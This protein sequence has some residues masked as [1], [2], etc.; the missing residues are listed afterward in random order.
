MN[1]ASLNWN[2]IGVPIAY[3]TN[4]KYHGKVV[5][6]LNPDSKQ[7]SNKPKGILRNTN[8]PSEDEIKLFKQ[9]LK[10]GIDENGKKLNVKLKNQIQKILDK[11]DEPSAIR[12]LIVSDGMIEVIPESRVDENGKDFPAH[13]MV[14]G[15]TGS[16]KTTWIKKYCS[17]LLNIK[18]HK[19]VCIFSIHKEGED[20][21]LS[22]LNPT[23][24]TCDQK[25]VDS[26]PQ[27]EDF[28]D[29]ICLFDDVD[30]ISD[31]KVN[32]FVA[33]FRDSL[34]QNGRHYNCQVITVSHQI[35]NY[36]RTKA[37]IAEV[38]YF[39]IFPKRGMA[40][41]IRS[42]LKDNLGLK[43]NMVEK[44]MNLDTRAC[45]ISQWFPQ[46]CIA[47]HNVFFTNES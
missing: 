9:I 18:S 28:K 8:R 12:E 43:K 14:T 35:K 15:T 10:K 38:P 33:D 36:T 2:R 26:N 21:S 42:F 19:I 30:L 20:G 7:K 5:S 47:D 41:Q 11:N 27:L 4:G 31:K 13:I 46:V 24:I 32:K 29:T 25:L 39:V 37:S 1:Q 16:G 3:V 22:G 17:V 40:S 6:L 45:M 34:L 23:F 44:I